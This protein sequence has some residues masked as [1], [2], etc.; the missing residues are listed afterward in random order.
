[1]DLNI[2]RIGRLNGYASVTSGTPV[3]TIVAPTA[4]TGGII[5]RTCQ[6]QIFQGTAQNTMALY[7]DTTAPANV[8]D[9]VRRVILIATNTGLTASTTFTT[10][11]PYPLYIDPGF[12]L[13]LAGGTTG[14]GGSVVMTY[15][16]PGLTG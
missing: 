12:G 4:N 9:V 16:L 10:Q 13:W 1:M 3:A 7:V 15:D 2:P 6:L 8:T 14:N 11:L 5:I